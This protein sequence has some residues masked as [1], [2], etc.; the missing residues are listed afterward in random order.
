V[1][2]IAPDVAQHMAAIESLLRAED[3]DPGRMAVI[4]PSLEDVFI[5]CIRRE[6]E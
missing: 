5:S 4:A 3:I 1:H 6:D 2:L